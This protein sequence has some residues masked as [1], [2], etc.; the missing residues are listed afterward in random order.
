MKKLEY[1]R[2]NEDKINPN[3]ILLIKPEQLSL[4]L[5]WSE[6]ACILNSQKY[7]EILDLE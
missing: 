3:E 5:K 7:K 1:R 2:N 6:N 4:F